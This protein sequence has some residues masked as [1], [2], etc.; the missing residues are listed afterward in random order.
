MMKGP[1]DLCV[2][3]FYEENYNAPVIIEGPEHSIDRSYKW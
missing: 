3:E 1:M 2:K